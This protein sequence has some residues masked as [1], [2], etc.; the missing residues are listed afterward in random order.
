M[1]GSNILEVAIGLILVFLLL[2]LLASA[3]QEAVESLLKARGAHLERGIRELLGDT[4]GTGLARTFYEH[5]MIAG[6]YRGTY[7]PPPTEKLRSRGGNLPNYIPARNFAIALIDIAIRGPDVGVYAVQQTDP[8]LTAAGLRSSVSRIPNIFVQRAMLSAIDHARGDLSLA[9]QNLEAWFDSAMDRVSGS[10]KRH[11]QRCLF[12]IGL[13]MTLILNVNTLTIADYLATDDVARSEV[14]ARA[15]QLLDDPIY[16]D[17]V[18]DSVVSRVAGRVVY[19]DLQTLRLPIGWDRRLPAPPD[20]GLGYW[21]REV[22]GLLLTTIAITLGAPFWFDLLNKVM[23][24][25]S[26]V[27]PREKSREEGSEDRQPRS[28]EA[29]DPDLLTTAGIAASVGAA[30]ATATSREAIAEAP[31]LPAPRVLPTALPFTEQEWSD[32]QEDGIL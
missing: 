3:V 16:R 9:Q 2:S 30:T 28:G 29:G 7:E 11:A 12:L 6:L 17:L 27:K 14:V 25:R 10:Y 22:F 23:V 15:Q 24:I 5:P 26:T 21:I 32:G 8:I 31:A 13:G 20:A 4:K 18:N 19:E 1:F